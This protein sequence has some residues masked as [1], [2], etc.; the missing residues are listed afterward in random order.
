M[1]T[2]ILFALLFAPGGVALLAQ[3]PT[4]ATLPTGQLL[5]ESGPTFRTGDNQLSS[6]LTLIAYGDQ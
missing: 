1:K 2:S 6:P 3:G 4:S 5:S